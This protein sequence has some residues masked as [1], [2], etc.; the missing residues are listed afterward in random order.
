[1]MAGTTSALIT[2][3]SRIEVS[4]ARTRS[5]KKKFPI[6]RLNSAQNE[7]EQASAIAY[8][9]PPSARATTPANVTIAAPATAGRSR[10]VKSESPREVGSI[11]EAESTT[12]A[13][14]RIQTRDVARS[15]C[16]KARRENNRSA[17]L[18]GNGPATLSR[19]TELLTAIRWSTFDLLLRFP[20]SP[21]GKSRT[22]LFSAKLAHERA[23]LWMQSYR[24]RSR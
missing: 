11:E 6:A 9:R 13:D 3:D 24:D 22:V 20:H 12:A 7:P 8:P 10:M 18:S 5:W 4:V 15:R 23:S 2:V 17:R 1:M 16:N 19:Q 14:R 21:I